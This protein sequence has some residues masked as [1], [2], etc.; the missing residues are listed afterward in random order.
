MVGPLAIINCLIMYFNNLKYDFY[1]YFDISTKSHINIT[2]TRTN[3]ILGNKIRT[4]IVH[5]KTNTSLPS[6]K[7]SETS[8]NMNESESESMR[9]LH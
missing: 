8:N 7:E 4:A 9:L 6:Y 3:N 1:I 2:I 5:S